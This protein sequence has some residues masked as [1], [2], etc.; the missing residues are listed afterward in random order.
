MSDFRCYDQ[1]RLEVPAGPV[2]LV[3]PNGAGKT[4]LLE[5]LSLLV[6]GR[7]L[8]SAKLGDLARRMG[9]VSRPWA[10]AARVDT[11][12]GPVDLGTGMEAEAASRRVRIDGET[13]KSQAALADVLSAQW[14]TPQMDRL[15]Q[16]GA[17]GRRRF[18]DRLVYGRDAA[19]AGRVARYE[20]TLRERLSLLRDRGAGADPAWL[21]ALEET[22]ATTG[23]AIA[24]ARLEAAGRLAAQLATAR[25]AEMPFPRADIAVE[26]AVEGW[27]QNGSALDAE[28]R[29]RAAFKAAR[30]EDAETGR[31]GVGPQRSDLRVF[32]AGKGQ[33]AELCSTGEQK[34]LLISLVLG[35]GQVQAAEGQAPPLLLLDEVAAHLDQPRREALFEELCALGGQAWLTGTEDDIFQPLAGTA[36]FVRVEDG[37]LSLAGAG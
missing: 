35:Q 7:G 32:H 22:L 13:Q 24:A 11:A 30:V 27:L 12:R 29:L 18:L 10:V 34:A 37:R 36:C 5:A 4:N 25:A 2:V 16:E 15:F 26:G 23:V 3:G 8:R 6:P 19:H 21:S 28:D 9:E 31:S 33:P 1:A 14:L 20:K 17:S